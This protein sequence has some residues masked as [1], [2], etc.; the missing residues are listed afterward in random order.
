MRA[1]TRASIAAAAMSAGDPLV[2]RKVQAVG[3]STD[4]ADA[5]AADRALRTR[6]AVLATGAGRNHRDVKLSIMTGEVVGRPVVIDRN[7]RPSF[8]SEL[9]KATALDT[10][11]PD[12]RCTSSA[13]VKPPNMSV[14]RKARLPRDGVFSQVIDQLSK[15]G[16]R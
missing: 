7:V 15:R 4:M 8:R 6:A 16:V 1:A 9:R 13:E 10:V 14:S 2:F 5:E 3:K 12:P 11:P